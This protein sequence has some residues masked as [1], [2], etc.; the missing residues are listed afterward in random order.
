MPVLFDC[1][2]VQMQVHIS[3]PKIPN[4]TTLLTILIS[5]LRCNY[6]FASYF[7]F[8]CDV[9]C[10]FMNGCHYAVAMRP[11]YSCVISYACL[12]FVFGLFD[13]YNHH[14]AQSGNQYQAHNQPYNQTCIVG[15]CGHHGIIIIGRIN[16]RRIHNGRIGR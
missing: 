13:H 14:G 1:L 8:I 3:F 7:V 5:G 11:V 10:A 6:A 9:S 2:K 16:H 12:F 4:A 15:G